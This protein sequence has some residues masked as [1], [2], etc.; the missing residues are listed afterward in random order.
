MWIENNTRSTDCGFIVVYIVCCCC[1]CCCECVCVFVFVIV[2]CHLIRPAGCQKWRL[3]CR[4]QA[5]KAVCTGGEPMLAKA[6]AA[7]AS[8][9]DGK[10]ISFAASAALAACAQHFTIRPSCCCFSML[11]IGILPFYSL[12]SAERTIEL[13]IVHTSRMYD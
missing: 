4:Q 6:A 10:V 12:P 9:A 1:C 7:A 11:A 3:A 2:G 8:A 5:K 13:T